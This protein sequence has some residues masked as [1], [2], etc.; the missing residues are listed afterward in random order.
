MK[1]R[2]ALCSSSSK[3]I[4]SSDETAV[5]SYE[6][7]SSF[8]NTKRLR[9]WTELPGNRSPHAPIQISDCV[10]HSDIPHRFEIFLTAIFRIDGIVCDESI[11]QDDRGSAP[12]WM[13]GKRDTCPVV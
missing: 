13:P 6:S 8:Q 12:A 3:E 10:T 1:S 7:S 9:L 4:T 5:R 2:R 11:G